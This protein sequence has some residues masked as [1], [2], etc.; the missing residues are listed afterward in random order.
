VGITRNP[1]P[2]GR[3]P[4]FETG[5]LTLTLELLDDIGDEFQPLSFGTSGLMIHHRYAPY[6]DGTQP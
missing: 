3:S 4:E 5:N 2:H 1:I 6:T